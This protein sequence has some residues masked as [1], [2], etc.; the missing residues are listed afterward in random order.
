[1]YYLFV[2]EKPGCLILVHSIML[3]PLVTLGMLANGYTFHGM[4]YISLY[5]T[6]LYK[7]VD[8][9]DPTYEELIN[10]LNAAEVA[11]ERDSNGQS[12]PEILTEKFS[13]K[14]PYIP[15]SRP[16]RFL[17]TYEGSCSNKAICYWTT[18]IGWFTTL[19]LPS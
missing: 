16:S 6:Q 4:L 8:Y 14:Y 17:D 13:S 15:I 5:F 7:M 3:W 18:K 2:F 10:F 1:M 11:S 12:V 9:E 19:L